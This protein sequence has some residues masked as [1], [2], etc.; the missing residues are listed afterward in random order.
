MQLYSHDTA[1]APERDDRSGWLL[2]DD[3]AHACQPDE[4]S[5]VVRHM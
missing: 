3:A 5:R 1:S 2:H 4:L